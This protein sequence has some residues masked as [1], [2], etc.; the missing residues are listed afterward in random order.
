MNTVLTDK[1]SQARIDS[2]LLHA[3]LVALEKTYIYYLSEM[4][5]FGRLCD[6]IGHMSTSSAKQH[7]LRG[8]LVHHVEERLHPDSCIALQQKQTI[9]MIQLS[10]KTVSNIKNLQREQPGKCRSISTNER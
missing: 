5:V 8:P 1:V 2:K 9:L 10:A 6:G 4:P 7:H 3:Q